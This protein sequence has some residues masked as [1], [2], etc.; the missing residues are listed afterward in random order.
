MASALSAIYS[1]HSADLEADISLQDRT[2]EMVRQIAGD[3]TEY[4]AYAALDPNAAG[5]RGAN[6]YIVRW[7]SAPYQLVEDETI[8]GVA[9]AAGDT[10]IWA[11]HT[12]LVFGP[13]A[14]PRWYTPNPTKVRVPSH[15]VLLTHFAM[16]PAKK[17]KMHGAKAR[18][19]NDALGKGARVLSE[20][21]HELIMEELH[22][23][24]MGNE[25][26]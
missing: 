20:D 10:V 4:G 11:E 18:M 21:D 9:C 25:D 14:R 7:T 17:E 22:A 12:N 23:R 16:P 13:S 5:E 15:L 2:D 26:A 3:G 1:H 8:D 24:D 19:M 6:Y